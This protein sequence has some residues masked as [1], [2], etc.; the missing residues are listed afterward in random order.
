MKNLITS[1]AMSLVTSILVYLGLNLLKFEKELLLGLA[2]IPFVALHHIYEALERSQ[3]KRQIIKSPENLPTLEGFA[4]PWYLLTIYGALMIVGITQG[5]GGIGAILAHAYAKPGMP[6]SKMAFDAA[7][8]LETV[9][10]IA[11]F[12]FTVVGCFF[13]GRWIGVRSRTHGFLSVC[14]TTALGLGLAHLLDFALLSDNDIQGSYST[15]KSLALFLWLTAG[16]TVL[17]TPI[18]LIGLWRGRKKRLTKYAAYLF[19]LLPVDSKVAFV[20]LAYEEA[21]LVA[22][23]QVNAAQLARKESS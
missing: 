19:S 11:A 1:F 2:S 8:P 15:G 14:V 23:K 21:R 3:A 20:D 16:G 17:L 13:V 18:G 5:A 4:M 10:A 6:S 12:P 22:S 9:M 7:F